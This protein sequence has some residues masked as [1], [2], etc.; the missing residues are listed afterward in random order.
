[1]PPPPPVTDGLPLPEDART[2]PGEDLA[3]EEQRLYTKSDNLDYNYDYRNR[4]TIT[5]CGNA[6]FSLEK[7]VF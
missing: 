7:G 4:V 6:Q 2:E 5:C 3:C 1:M